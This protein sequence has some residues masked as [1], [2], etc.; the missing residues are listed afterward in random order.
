MTQ[1]AFNTV[2]LIACR[3]FSQRRLV[4]LF[5]FLVL[6]TRVIV[7]PGF[8]P[9]PINS[10]TSISMFMLCGGDHQSSQ[11]LDA[12]QDDHHP[13]GHD[14]SQHSASHGFELCDFDAL[15]MTLATLSDALFTAVFGAS[16]IIDAPALPSA[17]I[18]PETRNHP[19]RAPPTGFV[20]LDSTP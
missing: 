13:M 20:S 11:L 5:L 14:A 4:L 16:A 9:S 18:R 19:A 15:S 12:W 3:R 10:G 8:M 6:I 1:R 2:S 17:S 7:P